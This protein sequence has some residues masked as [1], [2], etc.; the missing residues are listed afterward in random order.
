MTEAD[1]ES[2]QRGFNNSPYPKFPFYQDDII[3]LSHFRHID[4]LQ[5][6]VDNRCAGTVM[7]QFK[8]L[9]EYVKPIRVGKKFI[10]RFRHNNS[11]IEFVQWG[12]DSFFS[13]VIV[14]DPDVDIQNK[15]SQIMKVC[16]VRL[17][18]VEL[19]FDFYPNDEHDLYDLRR[20]LTSGLILKHSRA[21]CYSKIQE[22]DYIGK[23]GNVRKGSKGIRIYKKQ[24]DARY[25]LRM[26][27]QL[28][29]TFIKDNSI[30]LPVIADGFQLFDFVDYRE[31]LDED[32][33]LKMLCKKWRNPIERARDVE[34][35]RGLSLCGIYSWILTQ[36]TDYDQNPVCAQIGRFKHH[37]K[38]L[39]NRVSEFFPES[40]KKALIVEDIQNG[41]CR[42]EYSG[43]HGHDH[44]S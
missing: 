26:E 10:H 27:L 39:S 12:R 17:S 40:P 30:S 42:R 44:I 31:P 4:R 43:G 32:R 7:S 11:L 33:L 25:F 3:R 37:L 36:I 20:V 2:A 18:Q 5:F 24:R 22:T 35:L 1:M 34:M 19:A 13:T 16:S 9:F 6:S 15:I 23:G 28:N 21:G 8:S 41:F 29:R 14:H 38:N